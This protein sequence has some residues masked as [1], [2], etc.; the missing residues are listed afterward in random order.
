MEIK[1]LVEK[2]T[3]P[4]A[5]RGRFTVEHYDVNGNLKAPN[6]GCNGIVDEG[7]DLLLDVMFNDGVAIA[8]ASWFDGLID[9]SGFSALACKSRLRYRRKLHLRSSW[10][11]SVSDEDAPTR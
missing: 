6:W 8:N 1:S 2:V 10:S 11:R 7:K 5:L 3:N 9:L 4:S